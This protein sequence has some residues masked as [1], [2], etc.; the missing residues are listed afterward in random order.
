MAGE[1]ERRGGEPWAS[2][3]R[4]V[5]GLAGA[6]L[7]A[8]LGACAEPARPELLVI[9]V[10]TLRADR[11]GVE[12]APEL[13]GLAARGTRFTHASTPRAKTTPAL[14]SLWTGLLPAEHGVRDLDTPLAAEA[15]TFAEALGR[16]GYGTAAIVGNFV[17]VD[18]R[19]GLGQGFEVYVEDLPSAGGIP[20]RIGASLTDGALAA[21]GLG[22]GSADGAAPRE[23]LFEA[24]RPSFLWLHYMDPHG[25]YTAPEPFRARAEAMR[26]RGEALDPRA[27]GPRA[28]LAEYNVPADARLAEGRIDAGYVRALYDAEV[29]YVDGE[30]GRLLAGLEGAG[31]LDRTAIVVSA[32][33]GESLGENQ[34]WFEHGRNAYEATCRVPLIVA[35]PAGFAGGP[36]PGVQHGDVSLVDVA[37]T[38]LGLLGLPALVPPQADT[39]ALPRGRDLSS[40]WRRGSGGAPAVHGEKAEGYEL[41]GAVLLSSVRQGDWK[42]VR[43]SAFEQPLGAGPRAPRAVGEE[44]YELGSDPEE[45]RNLLAEGQAPDG[46]GAARLA[47][48]RAALEPVLGASLDPGRAALWLERR[49]RARARM[50]PGDAELLRRLGYLR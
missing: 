28:W 41:A 32:D 24:G 18:R 38:L 31:R 29:A 40:E 10:D 50:E 3:I 34:Y 35:W 12:R 17:C 43:R 19:S 2:G 30:I 44:L 27:L 16:A 46:E 14:A 33:H 4:P 6:L 22:P 21:Y 5:R 1:I 36:K 23:A 42:L 37:P 13:A 9:T 7:L 49:E 11:V 48:L 20:E 8:L 15:D 26:G 45:A 47:G 25:P 39:G